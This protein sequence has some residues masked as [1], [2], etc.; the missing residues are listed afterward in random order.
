MEPSQLVLLAPPFFL[1]WTQFQRGPN[2]HPV[3]TGFHASEGRA[4]RQH[5]RRRGASTPRIASSS[6]SSRRRPHPVTH[7]RRRR[8]RHLY[9]PPPLKKKTRIRG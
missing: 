7:R 6:G 8:R 2:Y 1:E 9:H 4:G 5:P 3:R